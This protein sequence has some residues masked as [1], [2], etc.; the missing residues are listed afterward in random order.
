M[1]GAPIKPRKS[2]YGFCE[3]LRW[4]ILGPLISTMAALIFLLAQTYLPSLASKSA[5]V[6]KTCALSSAV[7]ELIGCPK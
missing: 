3:G 2:G 7:A 1:S 4:L 5:A 6:S